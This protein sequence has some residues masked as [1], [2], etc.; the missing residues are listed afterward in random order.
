MFCSPVILTRSRCEDIAGVDLQVV[1]NYIFEDVFFVK[2]SS[3]PLMGM[4]RVYSREINVS[5]Y[6]LAGGS[7]KIM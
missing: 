7:V 1:R 2:M 6:Y 3:F 4:I 5:I